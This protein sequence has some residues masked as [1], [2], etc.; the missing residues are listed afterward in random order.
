MGV[1]NERVH[2]ENRKTTKIPKSIRGNIR[3]TLYSK[4]KIA[5]LSDKIPY[6]FIYASMRELKSL[7][8][9]CEIRNLYL[10]MG[11]KDPSMAVLVF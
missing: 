10:K 11:L 9:N 2:S 6:I 3:L 1:E 7:V 8:V 4:R 5:R